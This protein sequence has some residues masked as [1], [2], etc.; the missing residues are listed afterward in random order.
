M[1]LTG[2]VIARGARVIW[3]TGRTCVELEGVAI[4][5][6][7]IAASD[8]HLERLVAEHHLRDIGACYH[9]LLHGEHVRDAWHAYVQVQVAE[10][11]MYAMRGMHMFRF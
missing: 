8:R 11:S 1:T 4:S 10:H 7:A 2:G 3:I 6:G 5:D 9:K